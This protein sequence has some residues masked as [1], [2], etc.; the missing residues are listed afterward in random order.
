MA[1]KGL[2][3]KKLDALAGKRQPS[4]SRLWDGDGSGFGAKVS[5]AG[6]VSFFQFYYAPAGTID[7]TGQDI[8]GKRR[9]M[10]L[11]TYSPDYGL[12]QAR[13]DAETARRLLDQGIDPQEQ[14]RQERD[15]RARQAVQDARRGTVAS[16]LALT[17]WHFRSKGRTRRY[18]HDVRRAWHR[19]VFAV[20]PRGTKAA[21]VTSHDIRRIIHRPLSRGSEH[22]ARTLRASLHLAFKLA[23]QADNDPRNLNARLEFRMTGNPVEAV[24]LD[25]QVTPGE[26]EL[27]F[28]EISRVWH[29][30]EASTSTELD[31]LLIKL[32][33]AF[34][35]QHITEL[36][37]AAWTEFDF[38]AGKWTIRAE[39]HKNRTRDHLLPINATAESL[40]KQ[41]HSLTGAGRYLFPQARDDNKPMRIER[42]GAIISDLIVNLEKSGS[43]IDKFTA[44]DFRRTCKTRMHEIGI[45]KTTTNHIHNHDFGGVSAKHYDR[46]DYWSE[47]QRAMDAWNIALEAAISRKPVPIAKCRAALAW[48]ND[49][50]LVEVGA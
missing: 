34:G 24:P 43:P 7:A 27:S 29:G 23:M 45:P 30:I 6:R 36:R 9:F 1:K 48:R 3:A 49:S 25:V 20:V 11:G 17:L 4:A 15:H 38:S 47:K 12:A 28:E 50:Q 19:D 21:D 41:L 10:T 5:A 13:K 32:L 46:W 16:V 40:L 26:R 33:L 2:T 35:G 14:A 18:I 39:R 44:S 22:S 31:A 42:P 8:T 37:E